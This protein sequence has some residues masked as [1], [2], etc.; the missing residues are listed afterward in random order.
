VAQPFPAR[1][2][3]ITEMV[4]PFSKAPRRRPLI[5]LAA[6]SALAGFAFAFSL[7]WMLKRIHRPL[8]KTNPPAIQPRRVPVRRLTY[9]SLRPASMEERPASMEE[10]LPSPVV[11]AMTPPIPPKREIK[12]TRHVKP[13]V[14]VEVAPPE[15][16]KIEMPKIEPRVKDGRLLDPF[17]K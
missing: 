6:V 17:E 15:P 12:I 7:P 3:S 16:P 10:P 11:P 5:P 9:R 8:A 1:P 2:R 4:R 13:T 14:K